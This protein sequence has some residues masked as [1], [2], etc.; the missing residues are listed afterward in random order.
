MTV[1]ADLPSQ[2]LLVT[3]LIGC[4][5]VKI[6]WFRKK[7][8]G[9][10]LVMVCISNKNRSRSIY[11]LIIDFH[12]SCIFTFGLNDFLPCC[13]HE[14]LNIYQNTFCFE[15]ALSG[16]LTFRLALVADCSTEGIVSSL[17]HKGLVPHNTGHGW[18]FKD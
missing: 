18:L 6:N 10:T 2:C 1:V 11:A 4:N 12:Q 9:V 14:A 3:F 15:T 7:T 17:V 16:P 8:R 13:I 5:N